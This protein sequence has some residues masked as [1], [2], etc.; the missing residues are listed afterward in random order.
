VTARWK[1]R[2]L[3]SLRVRGLPAGAR[4]ELVC[5]GRG[6]PFTTRVLAVRGGRAAA[7]KALARRALRAGTL[8]EVRL[9]APGRSAQRTTFTVRRGRAPLRADA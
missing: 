5:T 3:R 2:R 7:P 9:A 8:V 4:A 6:C 1:A